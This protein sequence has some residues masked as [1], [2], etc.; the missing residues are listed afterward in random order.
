MSAQARQQGRGAPVSPAATSGAQPSSFINGVLLLLGAT[1]ALFSISLARPELTGWTDGMVEVFGAWADMTPLKWGA[2][3][4]AFIRDAASVW[5]VVAI[6]L[7]LYGAGRPVAALF[8]V[9]PGPFGAPALR[10]AA[11]FGAVMMFQHGLGLS[12]LLFPRILAVEAVVLVLLGVAFLV[13]DRPW[14]GAS[15]PAPGD[16]LPA[17][18]VLGA[19]ILLYGLTRLPSVHEDARVYHFALPEHYL[20]LHRIEAEPQHYASHIGLGAEM[21]FLI[22]WAFGKAPAAKFVNIAV[23]LVTCLVAGSV[24]RRVTGADDAPRGGA[25]P[26]TGAAPRDGVAKGTSVAW[27]ACAIYL[28]VGR[29]VDET[30][31]GKNDL[32]SALFVLA[33]AWAVIEAVSGRRGWLVAAA[34]FAGCA[35]AVKYTSGIFIVGMAAMAW[36]VLRPRRGQVAMLGALAV[37][38]FAAWPVSSWLFIGNPAYP[39]MSRVFPSL[40]WGPFYEDALHRMILAWCPAE[41]RMRIDWLVG[42]RRILGDFSIGSAFMLALAPAAF[43]LARGRAA[44]VLQAACA[45]AYLLWLPT[46]RVTRYMAP[47]LP[48]VAVLGA[49]GIMAPAGAAFQRVRRG[50]AVMGIV[51]F[52]MVLLTAVR[53]TGGP[54]FRYL[55]G[56]LDEAGLLRMSYTTW[57]EARLWVNRLPA[58]ARTYFIGEE[59]RLWF[60]RR[61]I[62]YAGVSEPLFWKLTRDSADPA[63]MR[64]RL[65]QAGITHVLY[66]SVSAEFRAVNWYEGPDWTAAQLDRYK[67]LCRRYFTPAFV[68]RFIDHANGGF[69]VFEMARRPVA[70][71]YP[72][73]YLPSTEGLLKGAY[74]ELHRGRARVAVDVLRDRLAGV[75]DVS[76]YQD[77]MG[78]FLSYAKQDAESL[79]M[80]KKACASGYRGETNWA[81][82]AGMMMMQGDYDAAFR[83][84]RKVMSYFP[85]PKVVMAIGESLHGRGIQRLERGDFRRAVKDLDMAAGLEPENG[86][87]RFR[88]AAALGGAGRYAEA[89]YHAKV[90]KVLLPDSPQVPALIYELERRLEP[91]TR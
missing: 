26:G 76:I 17:L 86:T 60:T 78:V 12:G 85:N 55:S 23:L 35:P 70:K 33:A 69:H 20:L 37:V 25:A 46:E 13:L 14:R 6:L 41:S 2:C 59:R 16:R 5:Q 11:G 8:P 52:V 68:P 44:R 82:Y 21:A 65:R 74:K 45:V 9:R 58:N 71:P 89:L 28:T 48:L 91:A 61:V 10:L 4:R 50:L 15:L 53:F 75:M 24:A 29:V 90:A 3:A 27:W 80:M 54:G 42:A 83:G 34:W 49:A 84:Y 40:G 73:Y 62:S 64:K 88:L 87:I 47:V 22:P 36:F 51:A 57:D 77:R 1:W 39:F 18:I 63:V 31:Q 66:N 43:L 32:L 79:Q 67:E 56:Q 19:F 81:I 38:P 30:W 72:L 7:A